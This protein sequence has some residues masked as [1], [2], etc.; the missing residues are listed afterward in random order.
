[1]SLHSYS[2]V[3]LHL[4]WATLERRPLLSKGPAAKVSAYLSQYA[5]EKGI[6]MKINYVNPDHVHALVDLPTHLCIEDGM[7][8]LKGGSSHWINESKLLPGKFGW[9]RGYGAFSGSQ[10]GAA[11][12]ARYIADQEEHHRKKSFGEEL[13]L[14]VER[15]ELRWKED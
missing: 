14:L 3:W 11:E 13:K 1:M 4:I 6:Y 15:Y 5:A 7:Q 12:V 2:R 9:G 8:L 10:S